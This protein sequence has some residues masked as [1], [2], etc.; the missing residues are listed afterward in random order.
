MKAIIVFCVI[1]LSMVAG[2]DPDNRDW[3]RTMSLYQIYPR[4]FK[5]S[6]GDGVGDLPGIT[7][8]LDHLSESNVDAFWLSPIYPSPMVDFGYDISDFKS[9]DPVFGTMQDF[10]RLVAVA[11]AKSLKVIVDFVPNHSSDQHEWFQKSL[12]NIEPYKDFYVWHNGTLTENGTLAPPNNWVSV[13]GGP[14]W[15]WRKER[16]AFYL[17]QFAPEQPDL[18]YNNERVEREMQSVLRFWLNKGVDGFRIDAVPFISEDVQYLDEP[19]TGQ[20]NDPNNYAYTKKIYTTDQPRTYE[21]VQGWRKVLDEYTNSSKIMMVEAYANTSMTMKYYVSGAHFP[22]NFG[23][24]TDVNQNSTASDFNNVINKWMSNMPHGN[25]ANWVAGNHDKPRLVTRFGPERARAVTLMTLLL[26]GISVTYNG[27][28]IGMEDTWISWEE[29]KDPQGC[30][31]GKE[32]YETNSR[33]PARTPFQWDNTVSAGFS[34]NSKTWLP[35]NG[36]YK[37][38][39]LAAEKRDS[40]SYYSFY[41]AVS[42]LKKSPIVQNGNLTTKLLNENV[43]SFARDTFNDGS[44]YAIMNLGKK[45]EMVDLSVFDNVSKQLNLYYATSVTDS[46]PKT[47]MTNKKV[48]LPSS[49]IAIYVSNKGSSCDGRKDETMISESH[50]VISF[51]FGKVNIIRDEWTKKLLDV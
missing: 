6:N 24:I 26:P 22:F 3:W 38:V 16:R 20:T 40:N 32:R 45:E 29:T 41:K 18:N 28:E 42:K 15:T 36:N 2:S 9:I 27:E 35:V 1:S 47:L 8:K 34:T 21:V 5:D 7:S 43:L 10:E 31:A 11:H 39:N 46:I 48:K 25:A 17:H 33:D 37:T 14:A 44:V 49:G 4:S 13:F 12:Q 30:N 50:S 23:M 19:L 51:T